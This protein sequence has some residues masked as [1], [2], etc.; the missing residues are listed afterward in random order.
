M[1]IGSA[2]TA[3][4]LRL[5]G[6]DLSTERTPVAKDLTTT[7]NNWKNSTATGQQAYVQGIQGTTVDPTQ[8]AA[9]NAQ[10]ALANYSQAI[11]SGRWQAALAAAGKAKWQTNAVAKAQNWSTGIAAGESAYQ[12]AM[13]TWLPIID[14]AAA[15]VRTMASGTLAASQARSAAFMQILYNRK[16]GL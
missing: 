6:L 15:Q 5:P 16:R 12:Q 4:H 2:S 10:A 1:Y 9:Q 3:P 7:V 11:T 14:S 13:T 8:L